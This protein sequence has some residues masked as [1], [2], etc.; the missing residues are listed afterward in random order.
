MNIGFGNSIL[1]SSVSWAERLV[2]MTARAAMASVVCFMWGNDVWDRDCLRTELSDGLDGKV[3][4]GKGVF[5]TGLQAFVGFQDG[6]AGFEGIHDIAGEMLWL[7]HL[8]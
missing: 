2:L 1:I 7:L 5:L 8:H 4:R 6:N 3:F